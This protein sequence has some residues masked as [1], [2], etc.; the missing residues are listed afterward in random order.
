ML[1]CLQKYIFC[2]LRLYLILN[3]RYHVLKNSCCLIG[4]W[5]LPP[6]FGLNWRFELADWSSS[7]NYRPRGFLSTH[8]NY[9]VYFRPCESTKLPTLR[10]AQWLVS[11]K[12]HFFL[13]ISLFLSLSLSLSPF[14]SRFSLSFHL[15]SIWSLL[16]R[17]VACRGTEV[18]LRRSGLKPRDRKSIFNVATD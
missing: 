8:R 4:R 12:P 1:R 13:P 9:F 3:I 11:L 14:S 2:L 15:R 18:D 16:N 5:L 6:I 17:G 7:F 10:R